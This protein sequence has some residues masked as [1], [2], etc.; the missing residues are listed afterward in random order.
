MP[1]VSGY[2]VTPVDLYSEVSAPLLLDLAAGNAGVTAASVL[3]AIEPGWRVKWESKY[4]V[5][6]AADGELSMRARQA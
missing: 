1:L 6:E 3:D 2:N 4:E 5:F